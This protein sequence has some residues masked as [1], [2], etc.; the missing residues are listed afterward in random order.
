M[1]QIFFLKKD[2]LPIPKFFLLNFNIFFVL[3]RRIT[4]C[5]KMN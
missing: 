2:T 3:T 1:I 5:R 4:L